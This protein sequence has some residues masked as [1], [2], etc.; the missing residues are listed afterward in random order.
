MKRAIVT[1]AVVF[2]VG[3]A[4]AQTILY[5]VYTQAGGYQYVPSSAVTE[6]LT[7]VYGPDGGVIGS[8]SDGW[9]WADGGTDV[10]V[11]DTSGA[12]CA[13]SSGSGCTVPNPDGGTRLDAPQGLSLSPGW[14]GEGCVLKPC[15]EVA[16]VSSWPTACPCPTYVPAHGRVPASG[17]C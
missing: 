9:R 15:V 4:F 5:E 13:C 2:S 6:T 1:T 11:L 14:S 10:Q 16:G 12:R 8:F 17:G 3:L 7:Y